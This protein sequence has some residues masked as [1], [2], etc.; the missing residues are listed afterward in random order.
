VD[1]GIAAGIGEADDR[2][3]GLSL[4]VGRARQPLGIGGRAE[5]AGTHDALGVGWTEA[6]VRAGQLPHGLDELSDHRIRCSS[7]HDDLPKLG[8]RI[9]MA[10]VW[11]WS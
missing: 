3:D 10:A 2:R 5:L 6:G 8:Q 7:W 1:V 4:Q 9:D 11:R